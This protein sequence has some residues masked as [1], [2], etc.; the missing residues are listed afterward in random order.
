MTTIDLKVGDLISFKPKSFGEDHW[1][2][3]G[4]V[5]DSY[6]HDDDDGLNDLIW[7]VWIDGG[8]YMVNRRNDDVVF[9]TIP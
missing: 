7:I 9:L 8:K 4:I 3:P 5:L 6:Q 1:S 2:N